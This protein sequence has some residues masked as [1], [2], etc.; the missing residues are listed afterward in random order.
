MMSFNRFRIEWECR[1]GMREL[2]EMIMPFYKNHFDNLSQEQQNTFVE[3][4][5]FTDPELFRWLM[6]QEKAPQEE[7]QKM[8]E[9]IQSKLDV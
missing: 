6:N 7:M 8:V 5:K 1:R 2:D 3:M 9:L 4:L